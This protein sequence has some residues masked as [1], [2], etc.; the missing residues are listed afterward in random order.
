MMGLCHSS[1]AAVLEQQSLEQHGSKPAGNTEQPF[2]TDLFASAPHPLIEQIQA[3]DP[4][5]LSPR[6]ALDLLY[7]LKREWA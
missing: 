6:Q 7:K 1:C 4:D 3:L 5:D 2:Q